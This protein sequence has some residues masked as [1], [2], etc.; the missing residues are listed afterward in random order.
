MAVWICDH[1]EKERIY[2]SGD[3]V[4]C[5]CPGGREEQRLEEEARK[6]FAAMTPAQ[7]A[8][9]APT[10]GAVSDAFTRALQAH[11]IGPIRAELERNSIL[12]DRLRSNR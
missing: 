9:S 2:L 4:S 12:M 11:Y 1:C 7:R 3:N 6:K 10:A 5:D 8:D